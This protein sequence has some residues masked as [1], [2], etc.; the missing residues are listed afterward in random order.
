MHKS[1]SKLRGFYFYTF[2]GRGDGDSCTVNGS[3]YGM[4]HI[5]KYSSYFTNGDSWGYGCDHGYDNGDSR[6]AYLFEYDHEV[7][8]IFSNNLSLE[9]PNA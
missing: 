5:F 2:C 1:F 3:G 9:K 8:E 6:P 7:V 4:G